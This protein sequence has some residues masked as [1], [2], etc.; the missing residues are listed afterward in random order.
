M[1]SRAKHICPWPGCRTIIDGDQRH[2]RKHTEEHRK[3]PSVMR[4]SDPFYMS[5]PWRR[6]REQ[7]LDE[8]P[9]CEDC[10]LVDRVTPATEID[11]VLPRASHPELELEITN[12]RGLCKS[13]HS[14]KTMKELNARRRGQ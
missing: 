9:L 14:S 1:P 12:C 5:A 13:H 3:R 4:K 2:C 10:L 7:V 6:L 11:H 8:Q